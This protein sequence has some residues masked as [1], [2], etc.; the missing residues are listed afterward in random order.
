MSRPATMPDFAGV[1]LVDVLANGVA[2]LIII[3]V[4]SLAARV[5]REE[6]YAEQADEVAAVMSH[7]FST[8][9]VLNRLGASPP[10][11]LHDYEMADK[12]QVL[13]PVTL[14]ILEL[15]RNYVREFYT[16]AVWSRRDLLQAA[17]PMSR[18][19][20]GFSDDQK[21]NLRGD[22]Y[23]VGS[24]YLAMAILREHGI[25]IPHWHFLVGHLARDKAAACPP[26]V[27]AK[28][29]AGVV[30]GA[31]MPLP[32]LDLTALSDDTSALGYPAWP[33]Q[34]GG[35]GSFGRDDGD[36]NR[37]LASAGL[38]PGNV[39]PGM[40]G[41]GGFGG[42]FGL[43]PGLDGASSGSPGLF[44]FARFGDGNGSAAPAD[45][46]GTQGGEAARAARSSINFRIALPEF[47]RRAAGSEL[48]S[49]ASLA[50]LF[51]GMLSYLGEMQDALDAGGAPTGL[52][53]SLS[54]RLNSAFRE[55]PTLSRAE[56]MV[57]R[58]L[59]VAFSRAEFLAFLK[60]ESGESEAGTMQLPLTPL[61]SPPGEDARLVVVPNR[62]TVGVSV[63]RSAA[64]P[65][66]D[67]VGSDDRADVPPTLAS[68]AA[69][70]HGLVSFSLNAYPGIWK[71]LDL[72]LEPGSVLLIPPEARDRDRVR[73]RAT[74][75]ISPKMDEAI[76]GFVYADIVGGARGQ[77]RVQGDA[78]RV[79]INGSPLVSVAPPSAFG[80][81]GWL[82][83]F[84]AAL[85]VG[86]GLLGVAC[87]WLI[88]WGTAAPS[89]PGVER[90]ADGDDGVTM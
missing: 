60:E 72:R 39:V 26:G 53:H 28:D 74:A 70:A 61:V 57:A 66:L 15:H 16:G 79:R 65:Q 86:L 47:I 21:R 9:L 62:R 85:V 18:W 41:G 7:K 50:A 35:L 84:Y 42:G 11:V 38:L 1:A 68:P 37:G 12:D 43:L 56:V 5:E 22:V 81:R 82:V 29:C 23:D 54:A 59:A 73:W 20:A 33:P 63:S 55:T 24:F 13:D 8:S 67:L 17:N 87:R 46:A 89:R 27:A 52:L 78:N 31:P 40:A 14:P 6:H 19:L 34:A 32:T 83:S 58:S 71:G 45:E 36:D 10:A 44:P 90:R 48:E 51:G 80:V 69:P 64:G 30:S 77:V 2:M 3:I 88:G 75:Y 25:R 4:V 76:F 49:V